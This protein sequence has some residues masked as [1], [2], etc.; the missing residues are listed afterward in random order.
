MEK[1][2]KG[3]FN[4]KVDLEKFPKIPP[5]DVKPAKKSAKP[6]DKKTLKKIKNKSKNSHKSTKKKGSSWFRRGKFL[7]SEIRN[8]RLNNLEK[9][10]T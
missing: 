10:E 5:K 8:F 9:S 6:A 1:I 3:K 7:L 2:A 4:P